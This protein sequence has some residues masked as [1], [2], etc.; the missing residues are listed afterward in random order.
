M[1]KEFHPLAQQ[2]AS[3]LAETELGPL[4]QIS[5]ALFVLGQERVEAALAE[6]LKIEAAGGEVMANGDEHHTLGGLFFKNLRRDATREEWRQIRTQTAALDG[7][8]IPPMALADR[9]EAVDEARGNVGAVIDLSL[10]AAGGALE[11]Q[12]QGGG[13]RVTKMWGEKARTPPPTP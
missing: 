1:A 6:A 2:V 12:A 7:V 11:P 13:Y 5:R 9:V 4:A 3:Q 10:S 8:G